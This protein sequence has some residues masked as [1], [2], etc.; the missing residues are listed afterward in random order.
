MEHL[1]KHHSRTNRCLVC[2]KWFSKS[3]DL[4]AHKAEKAGVFRCALCCKEFSRQYEFQKHEKKEEQEKTFEEMKGRIGKQGEL[5]QKWRWCLVELFPELKDKADDFWPY[6]DFTI[7]PHML[8]NP[9][10]RE[11]LRGAAAGIRHNASSSDEEYE[12]DVSG[13]SNPAQAQVPAK[14]RKRSYKHSK[15]YSSSTVDDTRPSLISDKESLAAASSIPDHPG[16]TSAPKVS[17]NPK[18]MLSPN[19]F[20]HSCSQLNPSAPSFCNQRY[21]DASSFIPTQTHT[22]ST[23]HICTY[24]ALQNSFQRSDEDFNVSY[25]NRVTNQSTEETF[26]QLGLGNTTESIPD[27]NVEGSAMAQYF[28]EPSGKEPPCPQS[29]LTPV[30]VSSEAQP[31]C[32]HG[33][34]GNMMDPFLLWTPFSQGSLQSGNPRTGSH[35]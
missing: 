3:E 1:K 34:Y 10:S 13:P 16:L 31:S 30:P 9:L 18:F 32:V 11:E 4:V 28:L 29:V 21:T 7:L 24:P 15:R 2:F 17:G 6:Y 8:H 25:S 33:Q 22:S 20:S 35:E 27:F 12:D 23:L 14:K 19:S 5:E 26:L